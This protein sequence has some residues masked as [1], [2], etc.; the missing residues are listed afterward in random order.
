MVVRKIYPRYST[1][2]FLS[3]TATDEPG[4]ARE[5]VCSWPLLR[6]ILVS[7]PPYWW[8]YAVRFETEQ[9]TRRIAAWK[10]LSTGRV[11][12][13]RTSGLQARKRAPAAIGDDLQLRVTTCWPALNRPQKIPRRL[14]SRGK[15]VGRDLRAGRF[16]GEIIS[17]RRPVVTVHSEIGT[18]RLPIASLSCV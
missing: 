6:I 7:L 5:N 13:C 9:K 15:Q 12:R 14:F 18:Y 2:L 16:Y 3:R 1:A 8:D 11:L 4:S 10:H 17:S